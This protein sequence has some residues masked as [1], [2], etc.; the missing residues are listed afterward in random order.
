M[1]IRLTVTGDEGETTSG[2]VT[3]TVGSPPP[4]PPPPATQPPTVSVTA[5]ALTVAPGGAVLLTAP[6]SDPDG[7]VLTY[8]WSAPSGTFDA[9]D[10]AAASW[11]APPEPAP[12]EIPVSV[13][14]DESDTASAGGDGDGSQAR[15][16]ALSGFVVL[17][18]GAL[19]AR[20]SGSTRPEA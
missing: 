12:V 10:R 5:D 17:L 1:P 6:A 9:T 19:V 3:I 15:S 14:D 7:G 13:T 16:P 20:S 18:L 2:T 4:P 8:A 11:T